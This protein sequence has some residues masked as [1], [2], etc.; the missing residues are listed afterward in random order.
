M[1]E[2]DH[3]LAALRARVRELEAE[4]KVRAYNAVEIERLIEKISRI[5]ERNQN[6]AGD[7][8]NV[9]INA[10]R[11]PTGCADL[12]TGGMVHGSQTAAGGAR[13]IRP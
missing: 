4:L 9:D 3:E 7:G 1:R 2:V 10:A 6:D 8:G 13:G 11:T 5:I 12:R